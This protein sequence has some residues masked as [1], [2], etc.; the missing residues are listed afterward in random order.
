MK[1]NGKTGRAEMK[2]RDTGG[3]E[4]QLHLLTYTVKE[5]EEMTS[6]LGKVYHQHRCQIGRCGDIF[7]LV[8]IMR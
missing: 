5:V 3:V 6:H 7:R 2:G 1:P 4:N 8:N